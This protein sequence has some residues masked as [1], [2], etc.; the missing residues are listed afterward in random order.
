MR[1]LDQV[2][3]ERICRSLADE[4]KK[5]G[6]PSVIVSIQ[7]GGDEI[8]RLLSEMLGRT[9]VAIHIARPDRTDVYQRVARKSK[10]LA[11]IVYELLFLLDR[12]QMHVCPEI[13]HGADVL[14]VDDAVQS[15]RTLRL[16]RQ[17]VER[18]SPRRVRVATVTDMRW[19]HRAE[20]AQYRSLVSFPWS[21]NRKG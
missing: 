11:K 16:A 12:P 3:V 8:G 4:I 17:W 19:W 21:K 7:T 15:G 13:S 6:T 14:I 1:R 5:D 9:V 10:L 18:S 20:Y 2:A